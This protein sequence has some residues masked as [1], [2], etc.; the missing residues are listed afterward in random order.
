MKTIFHTLVPAGGF[1]REKQN[2][3]GVDVWVP[4][5]DP[6]ANVRDNPWCLA[7]CE[8][9]GLSIWNHI[10]G[11]FQLIKFKV[12]LTYFIKLVRIS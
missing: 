3:G 2:L 8:K 9:S 11:G 4:I 10:V 12:G 5:W 7:D 6:N 1:K